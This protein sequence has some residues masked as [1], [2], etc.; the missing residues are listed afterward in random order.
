M[1]F[2]LRVAVLAGRETQVRMGIRFLVV[3]VLVAGGAAGGPASANATTLE[4][5]CGELQS[6][7]DAVAGEARHGEGDVIVLNELCDAA[8]LGTSSGVTLPAG[9]NFTLEGKSGTVSGFAGAGVTGPLLGT[10][11]DE[12]AGTPTLSGLVFEH[13]D[14]TEASALSVR[15]ARVTLDDDSF[16]GNREEGAKGHAA[17]VSAGQSDCN[18]AT[19]AQTITLTDSRIQKNKMVL[20]SGQGGGGAVVLGSICVGSQVVVDDNSF[21]GNTLQGTDTPE[22]P[23]VVGA[24]L[25]VV[26]GDPGPTVVSQRG[27]VFDSN[28]ITATGPSL[29]DYGGG[30]E[31][32][33]NSSLLSVG[34]RF[35]RNT[36]VGT[37]GS[38]ERWSWGAGLGNTKVDCNRSDLPETTVEDA[39]VTGNT[40][41]E[42]TNEAIGGGG[43]WVLCSHL[44]VLDSTITLNT[45]PNGPGVEGD[46]LGD[47]LEIENTILAGDI[48]DG[49]IVGFEGPGSFVHVSYSDAC[50]ESDAP[51]PG[52]GNICANPELDDHGNPSSVNVHES[53]SSPT[54]NVGSNALVPSGLLTDFYGHTRVLAAAPHLP[55]CGTA[56]V[57]MGASE[58]GSQAPC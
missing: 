51:F 38:P 57:D 15:A 25:D 16:L 6:T 32:L 42:G 39:V 53:P 17:F 24:G 21:T 22:G 8:N 43:I 5:G 45:A 48:G 56:V 26:G 33:E 18:A 13:A 40:L 55:R 58:F 37:I 27:N 20:G 41:E 29:A 12:E 31:W 28:H 52:P 44:R 54:I 23:W 10:V 2:E 14:L 3:A 4:T 49:E 9:S 35:T 19:G 1:V 47:Q 50:G 30:G 7:L 11:G 46:E 36:V 34:D